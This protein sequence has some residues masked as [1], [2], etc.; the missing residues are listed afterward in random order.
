[1]QPFWIDI[2]IG[3][4]KNS[5]LLRD[6]H[7]QSKVSEYIDFIDDRSLA[8]DYWLDKKWQRASEMTITCDIF[9]VKYRKIFLRKVL[10]YYSRTEV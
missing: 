5:Y 10:E 8:L 2:F 3:V 9:K 4:I 1:M 6:S 7:D